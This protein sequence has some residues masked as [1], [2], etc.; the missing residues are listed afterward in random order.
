[1]YYQEF[2]MRLVSMFALALV[3]WLSPMPVGQDRAAALSAAEMPVS[4]LVQRAKIV[5][6]NTPEGY[7]CRSEGG[8][9]RRGK[10][11]KI[12]KSNNS[13][14]PAAGSTGGSLWDGGGGGS[15]GLWG[16]GALWGG[17]KNEAPASAP[18]S[19][20]AATGTAA[21]GGCPPNSEQLGGYCIPYRQTC[22]RGLAANAAPQVCRT[23]Q[24]KLVCEFRTD[25]LKDCCCRIYSQN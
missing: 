21:A 5:C 18:A 24:E 19:G 9:I 4:S 13:S 11:P 15:G 23:S 22:N 7:R 1:M 20:R 12:P 10:M 8:A 3:L 25:G 6:G 16:G 2:F 17:K 14:P